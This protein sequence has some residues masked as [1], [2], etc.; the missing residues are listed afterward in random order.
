MAS[1]YY[2]WSKYTITND[3]AAMLNK[4]CYTV[5]PTDVW[6]TIFYDRMASWKSEQNKTQSILLNRKEKLRVKIDIYLTELS[7]YLDVDN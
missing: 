6:Q 4:C 5:W 3:S 7:H 2:L 1:D